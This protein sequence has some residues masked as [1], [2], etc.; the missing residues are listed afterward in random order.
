MKTEE[1][2]WDSFEVLDDRHWIN[3]HFKGR[4]DL[5]F[6]GSLRFSGQWTG[7]IASQLP[8]SHLHVMPEGRIVG[9]VRVERL[10]V[11][12]TLEDVDLEVEWLQALPGSKITGRIRAKRMMVAE[13]AIVQGRVTASGADEAAVSA[14]T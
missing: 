3:H 1:L 7:N 2:F 11:E 13:G 10:S 9:R 12:G 6:S 8:G 14:K 4:G 5:E